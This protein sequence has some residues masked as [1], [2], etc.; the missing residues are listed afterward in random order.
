MIASP[1]RA[2]KEQEELGFIRQQRGVWGVMLRITA[3]K[4]VQKHFEDT[5]LTCCKL[6]KAQVY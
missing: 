6:N 2:E 4:K 5:F 1:A 3:G